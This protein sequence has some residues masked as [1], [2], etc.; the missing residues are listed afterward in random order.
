MTT[1]STA[2]I[3]VGPSGVGPFQN[4]EWRLNPSSSCQLVEGGNNGPYFLYTVGEQEA[5]FHMD[6]LDPEILSRGLVV[7]TAILTNDEQS[8]GI[9][10]ATENLIET[11]RGERVAPFWEIA[12][13]VL[14]TISRRLSP[15]CRI[16]VVRLDGNSLFTSE[17]L[18]KLRI[19][20]FDVTEFD[21]SESFFGRTPQPNQAN[22][23]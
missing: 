7:M 2:L 21:E 1:V 13:G 4:R 5:V 18:D 19:L 8:L 23:F 20:D 16:G 15:L 3:L 17:V 22:E 14:L 10:R 11:D 12:D 6:S 9:L